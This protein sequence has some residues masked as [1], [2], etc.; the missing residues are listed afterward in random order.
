M[1]FQLENCQLREWRTS[2]AEAI[3]L[4][5]NNRKIWRNLRD[6]FPHPYELEDARQWIE[7]ASSELPQ[8]NFAITVNDEAVGGIGLILGGDVYFRTAEI[9][10][11]LGEKHWGN[12]IISEA[13]QAI[14]EYGFDRF[15]L[16]RIWAEVF[17][18]NP[19]SMR[20]LEKC[21]FVREGILHKAAVKDGVVIDAVRY[22]LVR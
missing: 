5:A 20:V 18:W 7:I 19:A 10:Y 16:L 9:G 17:E 4:H 15:K 21:G 2:D 8:V 6:R 14:S 22:A 13:V 3:V 12:G 1:E 11:W